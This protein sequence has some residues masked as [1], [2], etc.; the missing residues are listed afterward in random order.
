MIPLF[1]FILDAWPLRKG[2]QSVNTLKAKATTVHDYG[3]QSLRA[4]YPAK[5]AL[6]CPVLWNLVR[7]HVCDTASP[8]TSLLFFTYGISNDLLAEDTYEL[9]D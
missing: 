6:E 8:Y 9:L 4:N 1:F 3:V 5:Q 7:L 2:L